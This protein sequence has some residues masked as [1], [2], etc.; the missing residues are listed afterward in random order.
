MLSLKKSVKAIIE[1][2]VS[3]SCC[4]QGRLGMEAGRVCYSFGEPLVLFDWYS[5]VLGVG[6]SESCTCFNG[7]GTAA[8]LKFLVKQIFQ[9]NPNLPSFSLALPIQPLLSPTLHSPLQPRYRYSWQTSSHF[10]TSLLWCE[11]LHRKQG[12]ICFFL[13]EVQGD[14]PRKAPSPAAIATVP[15]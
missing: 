2:I 5:S 15:V 6:R 10:H 12:L 1:V 13:P 14:G 7:C 8:Y 9:P 4:P 11:W 3:V